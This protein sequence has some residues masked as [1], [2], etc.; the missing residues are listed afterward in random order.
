[1][2]SYEVVI[3]LYLYSLF[4]LF[5]SSPKHFPSLKSVKMRSYMTVTC[6]QEELNMLLSVI[7]WETR[8][9]PACLLLLALGGC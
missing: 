2:I 6:K 5:F 4:S 8:K 7:T 9:H 3:C 1:M